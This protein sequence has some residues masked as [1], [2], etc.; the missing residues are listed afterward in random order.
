MLIN[1]TFKALAEFGQKYSISSSRNTIVSFR[2]SS[3]RATKTARLGGLMQ[4][5]I[6][7]TEKLE[8]D[9]EKY[10]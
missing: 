4:Q 2:E 1:S 8:K 5:I 10:K 3:N 7:A 6:F 9:Y